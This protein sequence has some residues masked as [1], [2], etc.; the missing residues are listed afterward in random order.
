MQM[1][2]DPARTTFPRNFSFAPRHCKT[3]EKIWK[4]HCTN[5]FRT[6]CLQLKIVLSS[7]LNHTKIIFKIQRTLKY[8]SNSIL[9]YNFQWLIT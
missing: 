5:V 1:G 7:K 8:H 9:W 2:R 6:Q 4:V 3:V